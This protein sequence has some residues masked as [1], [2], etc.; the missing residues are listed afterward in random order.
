MRFFYVSMEEMLIIR[1]KGHERSDSPKGVLTMCELH[2]GRQSGEWTERALRGR[3]H[4][5]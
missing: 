5:R 2:K 4:V 1:G 3:A